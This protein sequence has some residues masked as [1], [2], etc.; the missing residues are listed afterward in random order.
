[1]WTNSSEKNIYN[2][3]KLLV[4]IKNGGFELIEKINPDDLTETYDIIGKNKCKEI[5]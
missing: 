2:N 3:N 4:T 5:K 1:M